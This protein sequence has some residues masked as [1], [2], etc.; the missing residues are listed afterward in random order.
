MEITIE[1]CRFEDQ[2]WPA[3]RLIRYQ[4]FVV[5][6]LVSEAEEYDEYEAGCPH[7]LAQVDGRPA[8]T[9][10]WRQTEKGY[11][12]E[13]FAVLLPYRK[14]G[15]GAALVKAVLAEVLPLASGLPIYL[16]AQIQAAPFYEKLG[17]KPYGNQ[18]FEANIPHVTMKFAG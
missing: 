10:R 7:F 14:L 1:K 4:V 5:E 17:F 18:F 3:I 11:K 6:Q 15:V 16:H 2:N 13:R 12:L 9:A 8:G